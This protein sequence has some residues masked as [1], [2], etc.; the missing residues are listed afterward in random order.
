M[1]EPEEEALESDGTGR[2]GRRG[3]PAGAWEGFHLQDRRHQST[4]AEGMKAPEDGTGFDK[5]HFDF[6]TSKQHF[7]ATGS[8]R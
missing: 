1:V 4:V 6:G 2:A 3:S 7:S 8:D 5:S